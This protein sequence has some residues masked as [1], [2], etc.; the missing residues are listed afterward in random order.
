MEEIVFVLK[1]QQSMKPC[2]CKA[3][4]HKG[5][6]GH[7]QSLGEPS[8]VEHCRHRI[9][10]VSLTVYPVKS[11]GGVHPGIGG[12]DDNAGSHPRN[13]D[14]DP[15]SPMYPRMK[16]VPTVKEQTKTNSFNKESRSLPAKRH[17]EDRPGM[18]HKSRP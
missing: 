3:R 6:N 9:H 13:P 5:C 14:N 12:D 17:S 18:F 15:S 16:P 8:I 4:S 7:M 2:Y 1:Q 10:I 11:G